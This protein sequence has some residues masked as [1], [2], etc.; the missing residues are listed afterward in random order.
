MVVQEQ[1][2]IPIARSQQLTTVDDISDDSV[3][4]LGVEVLY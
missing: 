1:I 2:L 4:L 3:T